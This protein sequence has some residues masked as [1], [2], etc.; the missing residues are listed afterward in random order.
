MRRAGS[1]GCNYSGTAG[2]GM[3]SAAT[4]ACACAN[5]RMR[6][7]KDARRKKTGVAFAIPVG[8]IAGMLEHP[9]YST[10]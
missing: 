6:R 4:C 9:K 8:A 3:P 5:A 1:I 10:K 7:R 2:K